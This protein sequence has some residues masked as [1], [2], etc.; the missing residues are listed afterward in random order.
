MHSLWILHCLSISVHCLHLGAI[1]RNFCCS[2]GK[3]LGFWS[4]PLHRERWKKAKEISVQGEHPHRANECPW[5]SELPWEITIRSILDAWSQCSH[6]AK[7]LHSWRQLLWLL[8]LVTYWLVPLAELFNSV[9]LGFQLYRMGIVPYYTV[10]T[11]PG[12]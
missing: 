3:D 8:S 12:S 11:A 1:N 6:V 9:S 10:V 7:K 2:Q 4:S 5:S